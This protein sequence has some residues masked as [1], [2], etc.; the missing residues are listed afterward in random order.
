MWPCNDVDV[1][2]HKNS[3]MFYGEDQE[4]ATHCIFV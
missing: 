2:I 4:Y 3:V 1:S